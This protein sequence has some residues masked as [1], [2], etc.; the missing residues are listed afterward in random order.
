MPHN[1]P[2]IEITVNKK[3]EGQTAVFGVQGA[4]CHTL[5][6]GFEAIFGDVLETA[7]TMEA[8]ENP[9]EVE[10]KSEHKG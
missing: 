5:T 9:E 8:F 7:D 4:G 6:E 2:R 3:G 1:G 10:I